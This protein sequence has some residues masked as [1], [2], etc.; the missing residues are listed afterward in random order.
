[1]WRWLKLLTGWLMRDC[2]TYTFSALPLASAPQVRS[3]RISWQKNGLEM[4][5]L[6]VLATADVVVVRV[7]LR[8]S[9]NRVAKR[10]DLILRTSRKSYPADS[11][12]QEGMAGSCGVHRAEFHIDPLDSSE[13]LELRWQGQLLHQVSVPVMSLQQFQEQLQLQ[14]PTLFVVLRSRSTASAGAEYTV[15][16]NRYLRPQGR[17]FLAS[18][19]FVSRIPL[20]GL[21]D[22][23]P[24]LLLREEA[25]GQA[26][27]IPVRLTAEQLRSHQA[28]V[29]VQ[30]PVRPRRLSVWHVEWR[31][32]HNTTKSC[33][34]LE[35]LPM[36]S[37]HRRL[38]LLDA[39]FIWYDDKTTVVRMDKRLPK[40]IGA[41]RVGPCFLLCT[42]EPGLAF[43]A[44]V[45]VYATCRDGMKPRLLAQQEILITDSPAPYVPGTISV[46]D[47]PQIVAFELRC[48]GHLIGHLP[49]CPVPTARINGEGAF[50]GAPEDLPWSPA[51]DEELRERLNRLLEHP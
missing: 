24:T 44:N 11:L 15:A 20:V 13:T 4:E 33:S 9:A 38:Q 50:Q 29:T 43:L 17:T 35:V 2:F 48:D 51:L 1:M 41:G 31:L 10:S 7:E 32:L 26:W 19:Q 6:P 21:V 12:I 5:E 39:H 8:Y 37:L 25:S 23:Q 3:V 34:Q 30:C 27:E 18:V 22:C 16:C 28:L 40:Q 36:R 14:H 42:K 46:N 49:L 47:L 45:E